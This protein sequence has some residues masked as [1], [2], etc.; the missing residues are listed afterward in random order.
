MVDSVI[1]LNSN[2]KVQVGL[3][4]SPEKL[5]TSI[6]DAHFC[7]QT[8][9]VRCSNCIC[10]NSCDMIRE[11]LNSDK[12]FRYMYIRWFDVLSKMFNSF[13]REVITASA[14]VKGCHIWALR[15][16]YRA[17]S[18]MTRLSLFFNCLLLLLLTRIPSGF[19]LMLVILDKAHPLNA[20]FHKFWFKIL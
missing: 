6:L 13:K 12:W 20:D 17:T 15:G 11:M 3:P 7:H 10:L 2:H 9:D 5:P 16:L 14:F 1:Y 8:K 4:N 19:L 18:A